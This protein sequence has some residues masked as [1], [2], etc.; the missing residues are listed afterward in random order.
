MRTPPVRRTLRTLRRA[1]TM[2]LTPTHQRA[3]ASTATSNR[4]RSV[5]RSCAAIGANR[6]FSSPR[7]AASLLASSIAARSGSIA[8][9]VRADAAYPSAS[10]PVPVP[11]SSTRAPR[12]RRSRPRSRSSR[13]AS[14][15]RVVADGV[16]SASR[17]A[18][19][20]GRQH[21]AAAR[22]QA[23]QARRIH[24]RDTHVVRRL[25]ADVPPDDLEVR[26]EELVEHRVLGAR[27]AARVPPEPVAA[28]RDEQRLSHARWHLAD[29]APLPLREAARALERAPG[30]RV[31]G[32]TDPHAVVRVDPR[33]RVQR[34]EL[35]LRR[36]L[37]EEVAHA[38]GLEAVVRLERPIEAAKE[39]VP[40][41]RVALPRVLT[42][43]DDRGEPRAT[44]LGQPLARAL[45][46]PQ[47]VADRVVRAHLPV[48]EADAIRQ[49][50][51]AEDDRAAVAQLVRTVEMPRLE[52]RA[53]LVAVEVDTDRARQD[54][55]VRREPLEARGGDRV[56]HLRRDR[57]LRGPHAARARAEGTAVRR[58]G[59]LE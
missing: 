19:V 57:S 8:R 52:E 48:G 56:G 9:T 1:S 38:H 10:R 29:A 44:V 23:T 43:E 21:R 50:V 11:T 18:T 24:E 47:E 39:V 26:A 32:L 7:R 6:T 20:L 27:V 2:P 35:D 13:A 41:V 17:S 15:R 5:S 22:G 37:I 30:T 34:R 16:R 3:H 58:D 36:V 59:L 25:A 33:P 54:A 40:V 28:F 53:D 42:V 46:L 45:E 49:H 14:G 51:V 31:R 55:L 12:V 4:S